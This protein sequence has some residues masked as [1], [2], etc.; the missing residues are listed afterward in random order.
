MA[1]VRAIAAS[2]GCNYCPPPE[3]DDDS[4]DGGFTY[5]TDDSALG[6][7]KSPR[8]DFQLKCHA[9]KVSPSAKE[10]SFKVKRK[11]YRDLRSQKVSVPRILIVVLVPPLPEDWV[12]HHP[13]SKVELMRCAYW[14][15]L[16]GSPELEANKQSKTIKIPLSNQ[17]NAETFMSFVNR[18]K[19]GATNL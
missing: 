4:I 1:F 18:I 9:L 3:S 12:A 7:V 13:D 14:A 15:S 11:N 8:F 5:Y 16:W 2:C 10:F 6:Q 19:A 17:L